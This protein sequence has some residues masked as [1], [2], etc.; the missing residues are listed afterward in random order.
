MTSQSVTFNLEMR[1][2]AMAIKIRARRL[3]P[4]ILGSTSCRD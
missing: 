4:V 2:R 1:R 3:P